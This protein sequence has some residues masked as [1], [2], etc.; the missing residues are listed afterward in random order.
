MILKHPNNIV[1][2]PGERAKF[3]V[4]TDPIATS[5]RWHFD[6]TLISPKDQRYEG[7]KTDNLIIKECSVEYEG[8]YKCKVTD[9]FGRKY[10]SE[11]AKLEIGRLEMFWLIK[12]TSCIISIS[13]HC[14]NRHSPAW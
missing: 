6:G 11:D 3:S 1:C 14:I 13:K 9:R 10:Y 4:R 2:K 5:Y 12:L 7:S 8:C